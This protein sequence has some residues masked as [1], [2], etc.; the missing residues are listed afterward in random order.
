MRKLYIILA[1]P[2]IRQPFVFGVLDYLLVRSPRTKNVSIG[3]VEESSRPKVIPE[4]IPLR[5]FREHSGAVQAP[6]VMDDV[7]YHFWFSLSL[8]SRAAYALAFPRM[9]L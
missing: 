2:D 9:A 7:R 8:F 1:N 5:L 6:I 3:A 4:I